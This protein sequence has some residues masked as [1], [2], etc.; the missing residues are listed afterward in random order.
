ML[1][2]LIQGSTAAALLTVLVLPGLANAE[3]D[4]AAGAEK[5][6]HVR[7]VSRH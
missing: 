3:G 2:K 4:A 5:N 1:K 7:C 6:N